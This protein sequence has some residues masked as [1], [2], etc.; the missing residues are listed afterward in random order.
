MKIDGNSAFKN[1]IRKSGFLLD[2]EVEI[3]PLFGI[4][5]NSEPPEITQR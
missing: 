4:K 1:M 3:K 2:L 5:N